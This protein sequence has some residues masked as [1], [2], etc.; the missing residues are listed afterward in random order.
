[1]T[2]LLSFIIGLIDPPPEIGSNRHL[3]NW[4]LDNPHSDIDTYIHTFKL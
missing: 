1:M 3:K 4:L 2:P